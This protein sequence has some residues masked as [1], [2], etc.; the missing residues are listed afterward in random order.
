MARAHPNSRSCRLDRPCKG[1][2]IAMQGKQAYRA[3]LI[4]FAGEIKPRLPLIGDPAA[5]LTSCDRPLTDP[6]GDIQGAELARLY[7][8]VYLC[9]CDP[10]PRS[11]AIKLQLILRARS[12][13]GTPKSAIRMSSTALSLRYRAASPAPSTPRRPATGAAITTA[14]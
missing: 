11:F 13:Q 2:E 12:A 14:E 7:W 1:L 5:A 10:H 3:S 4:S 6:L 8:L 9:S